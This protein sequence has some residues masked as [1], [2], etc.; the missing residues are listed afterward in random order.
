MREGGEKGWGGG[1]GK[2][3]R[4]KGGRCPPVTQI[5]GSAPGLVP[6]TYLC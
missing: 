4:E 1:E 2:G 6:V 5:P 3:G